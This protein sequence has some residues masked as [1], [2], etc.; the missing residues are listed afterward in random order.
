MVVFADDGQNVFGWQLLQ[1]HHQGAVAFGIGQFAQGRFGTDD[2]ASG[3]QAL[4]FFN[5]GKVVHCGLVFAV[6]ALLGHPVGA[7]VFEAACVV[8]VVIVIRVVAEVISA[9]RVVFVVVGVVCF[10]RVVV[11]AFFIAVMRVVV[12][13]IA[14]RA[15]LALRS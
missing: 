3:N 12:V 1:H 10:V 8:T 9:A 6:E 14:G 5:Q 15:R 13:G 4:G 2:V 7:S 11:A